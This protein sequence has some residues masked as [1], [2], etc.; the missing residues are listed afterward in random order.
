MAVVLVTTCSIFFI[1]L[2]YILKFV[3]IGRSVL[4]VWQLSS[5]FHDQSSPGCAV[6]AISMAWIREWENFFCAKTN[7]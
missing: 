2:L 4:C 7:G 6:Y 3:L 5:E 1:S